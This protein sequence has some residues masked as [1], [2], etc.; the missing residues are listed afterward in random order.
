[1]LFNRGAPLYTEFVPIHDTDTHVLASNAP[2]HIHLLSFLNALPP[3]A[4]CTIHVQSDAGVAL[5]SDL[6]RADPCPELQTHET[7]AS[8]LDALLTTLVASPVGTAL[9]LS[10]DE[11][12]IWSTVPRVSEAGL[13][14]ERII[15]HK[16]G[17][18]RR[19]FCAHCGQISEA[20]DV[21]TIRCSTC[22]TRLTI[23][24]HFSRRLGSYLGAMT[25]DTHSPQPP[26]ALPVRHPV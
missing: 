6:L 1:M 14:D 25:A 21:T 22:G 26:E 5:P 20:D 16:Q 11:A 12:F 23:R 15:V 7:H 17:S 10:G 18:K 19:V 9:Y 3:T 4:S 13:Q 24:T 8:L 2:T